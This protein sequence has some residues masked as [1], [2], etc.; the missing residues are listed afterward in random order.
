MPARVPRVNHRRALISLLRN[1]KSAD[2]EVLRVANLAFAQILVDHAIGDE[3]YDDAFIDLASRIDK[4][5]PGKAGRA[6]TSTRAEVPPRASILEQLPQEHQRNIVRSLYVSQEEMDSLSEGMRR[7]FVDKLATYKPDNVGNFVALCKYQKSGASYAWLEMGLGIGDEDD[8]DLDIQDCIK[9]IIPNDHLYLEIL[10]ENDMEAFQYL[11]DLNKLN[12]DENKIANLAIDHIDFLNALFVT[13]YKSDPKPFKAMLE[14]INLRG[15]GGQLRDHIDKN[16]EGLDPEFLNVVRKSLQST[17]EKNHEDNTAV[18]I[19]KL[20]QKRDAIQQRVDDAARPTLV[21]SG[22][23]INSGTILGGVIGI[24]AATMAVMAASYI[25]AAILLVA[26]PLAALAPGYQD[27]KHEQGL[28]DLEQD[29]KYKEIEGVN[30]EIQEQRDS[31][32]DHSDNKVDKAA[33]KFKDAL[34]RE[35]DTKGAPRIF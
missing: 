19:K 35:R 7:F 10:A 32:P 4:A 34:D 27:A 22:H 23:L 28:F 6:G 24:F 13:K 8:N 5:R 2:N 17:A 31:L 11:L 26:F 21:G 9:S 33:K 20:E 25:A 15:N 18:S 3:E 30:K 12:V 16:G 1:P 29:K 14:K